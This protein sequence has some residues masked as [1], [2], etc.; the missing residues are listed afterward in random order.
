MRVCVG[1]GI[2]VGVIAG[3]GRGVAR[4]VGLDV[5]VGYGLVVGS[6]SGSVCSVGAART[7]GPS[8]ARSCRTGRDVGRS[9]TRAEL[10]QSPVHDRTVRS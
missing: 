9:V 8:G 3:V 6:T 1:V 5:L 2:G 7:I 4:G 10:S